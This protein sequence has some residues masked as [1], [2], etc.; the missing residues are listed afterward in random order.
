MGIKTTFQT[1]PWGK[2]GKCMFLGPGSHL[3][4][5]ILHLVSSVSVLCHTQNYEL[6]IYNQSLVSATLLIAV[7]K[8]M[9]K[10]TYYD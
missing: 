7:F 10:A 8:T 1:N 9:A 6:Y 2:P 3:R 4:S 5:D